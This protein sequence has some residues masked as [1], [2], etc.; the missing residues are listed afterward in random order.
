MKPCL[1]N[2]SWVGIHSIH[3]TVVV[4]AAVAAAAVV[5]D[6]SLFSSTFSVIESDRYGQRYITVLHLR[7][8]AALRSER[9]KTGKARG[10]LSVNR[11]R[12]RDSTFGCAPSTLL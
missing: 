1:D 10:T 5:L 11:A 12:A 9:S 2:C 8:R 3:S 7:V 6:P 4:V